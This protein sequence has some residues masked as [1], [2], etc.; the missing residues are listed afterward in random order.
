M[1][2]VH[3]ENQ[4]DETESS[5]VT[6]DRVDPT[7]L[8]VSPHNERQHDTDPGEE[9]ID[10]IRRNGVEEAIEV[11]PTDIEDCTYEIIAGQRRWKAAQAAGLDSVPV[12]VTSLSDTEAHRASIRENFRKQ[13]SK[14]ASPGD[15]A[16]AID[17]L[18]RD[19]GNEDGSLPSPTQ[20]GNEL[21]VQKTTIS[22]WIEP[23]RPEWTN[24]AI[25]PRH[26]GNDDR[27]GVE[28]DAVGLK[29]LS[30]IRRIDTSKEN[31]VELARRV[32]RGRETQRTLRELRNDDLDI[33]DYLA[34]EVSDSMNRDPSP[35]PYD[36]R[37]AT[38][39]DT[40]TNTP[41]PADTDDDVRSS[42]DGGSGG[43]PPDS[44]FYDELIG[45]IERYNDQKGT[46]YMTG[47]P[48]VVATALTEIVEQE[49]GEPLI[50]RR[51]R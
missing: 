25:D 35:D 26:Q 48:L 51:R 31:R 34:G 5:G 15:R 27:A 19:M 42:D 6:Y 16:L 32:A 47:S 44:E 33:D 2:D 24:T 3:R 23:L 4:Q 38:E 29:A 13:F 7:T 39:V 40:A 18:W 43:P 28:L 49:T 50:T 21:D 9:F 45:V 41:T 37:T 17:A 1:T 10:D 46:N 12:A 36:D 14:D 22:D 20:I 8:V 30:M 11:R